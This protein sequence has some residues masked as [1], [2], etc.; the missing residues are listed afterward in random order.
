MEIF[1]ILSLHFD[2]NVL[3]YDMSILFVFFIMLNFENTL[4]SVE[5]V[6]LQ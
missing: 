5:N 2:C 6:E 4:P 1:V 3:F